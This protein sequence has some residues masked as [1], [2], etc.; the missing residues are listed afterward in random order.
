[1]KGP[2]GLIIYGVIAIVI[3]IVM[4]GV[5]IGQLDSAM[6]ATDPRTTDVETGITTAGGITAGN[7]TFASPGLWDDDVANVISFSSN[8]TL[9]VPVADNYT[10]ATNILNLTGLTAG[11]THSINT[12]YYDMVPV[13]KSVYDVMGIYGIIFWIAITGAGLAMLGF[14]I[15][16]TVR[17]RSTTKR[18]SR[19]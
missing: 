1:M 5:A 12:T 19:R 10:P 9:D 6:T 17:S 3:S 16:G 11:A 18:R 13:L 8:V 2:F 7:V 14:G 15:V 4:F